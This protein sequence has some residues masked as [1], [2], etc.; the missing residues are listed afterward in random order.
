[1]FEEKF[2]VD[3]EILLL[4]NENNVDTKTHRIEETSP[5]AASNLKFSC[6]IPS[7]IV[8][9][10]IDTSISYKFVLILSEPHIV[11]KIDRFMFKISSDNHSLT[12]K[13]SDMNPYTLSFELTGLDI[14]LL[15]SGL[16]RKLQKLTLKI[17]NEV[18]NT[19]N[20]NLLLSVVL[21]I[22]A[23]SSDRR[24][25]LNLLQTSESLISDVVEKLIKF[26]NEN[27]QNKQI[28]Q[29]FGFD[30]KGLNLL[31]Y[32]VLFNRIDL[33]DRLL[34]VNFS[35][36][37][38]TSDG[39]SILHLA[40]ES[41]NLELCKTILGHKKFKLSVLL[42]NTKGRTALDIAKEKN[43]KQ[44]INLLT[45]NKSDNEGIITQNN[46]TSLYDSSKKYQEDIVEA[47]SDLSLKHKCA[48]SVSVAKGFSQKH[49]KQFVKN[50]FKSYLIAI[51][52]MN[53]EERNDVEL[54][55]EKIRSNF[56][57]WLLQ[58]KVE[59]ATSLLHRIV[60]KERADTL[61]SEMLSS[62]KDEV[63]TKVQA[64]SKG[65]I[66]RKNFKAKKLDVIAAQKNARMLLARKSFLQLQK[67]VRS[68]LLIQKLVRS[69]QEKK[70]KR[71]R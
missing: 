31:H 69:H 15:T 64:V 35:P 27:M 63:A 66:A 7:Q 9:D 10:K 53:T 39:S 34:S 16:H 57:Q 5:N 33:F 44:I 17:G 19:G 29:Y 58:K 18:I 26:G 65:Y 25:D 59:S 22:T 51:K 60:E 21:P 49:V 70:R 40:V 11:K 43:H 13:L 2:D 38:L 24:K 14:L 47:L 37:T 41:G 55:A 48:L 12:V 6:L 20:K 61:D 8:V 68:I 30:D 23:A 32:S 52:A 42:Q 4:L 36:N 62:L 50:N 56:R 71:K 28:E 54:E 1:M 46:S 67:Q 3:D 45:L